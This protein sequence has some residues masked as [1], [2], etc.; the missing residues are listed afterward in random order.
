MPTIA[1]ARQ[2]IE[3]L[4]GRGDIAGAA[5]I[6]AALEERG[7][8]TDPSAGI[9]A[10]LAA[11]KQR[12]R[13]RLEELREQS[14][15]ASQDYV[16]SQ[17]GSFARG[18]DIGTD[19]IG[20]ATG[21]ALEGIGSLL[22]VEG[23]EQYGAEVALENEADAQRKSRYQT[24]FDDI[25]GA[26]DFGS[27]LGGLAGESSPQ[28]GASIA[29]G[30]AGAKI[31]AS[32]G[33]SILP[34]IGTAAGTLIGGVIGGTA[35][36]I[37][38]FFG[39][40]RERQ[41]DAIDR[42]LRTEVSE[43]AA[44]LSSIPQAA[45]D[46]VADRLLIGG[47]GL[48]SRVVG[49]GGIFTRGVKGAGTG[50]LAEVPTE[51]GQQLIE[52]AQAG[53]P[54][55]DEE[56]LAEYREAGI[57]GGLLGGSIRGTTNILGGD[58]AAREDAETARLEAEDAAL[59]AEAAA[60]AAALEAE[61]ARLEEEAARLEEVDVDAQLKAFSDEQLAD[62]MAP[63][64]TQLELGEVPRADQTVD[65]PEDS[66][67]VEEVR[68]RVFKGFSASARSKPLN[69]LTTKQQQRIA[70]RAQALAPAE[71][72]ALEEVLAQEAGVQPTTEDAEAIKARLFEGLDTDSFDGVSTLPEEQQLQFAFRS[73][74]L[75]RAEKKILVDAARGVTPAT[76]T[77]TQEPLPGLEPEKVGPQLQGLP[78]P[79]GETITVASEGEA[80]TEQQQKLVDAIDD[81]TQRQGDA[82]YYAEEAI[83]GDMPEAEVRTARERDAIA[84]REQPDLFPTEL[85]IAEDAKTGRTRVESEIAPTPEP[86]PE[87]VRITSQTL[88]SLAV[89]A[90]AP[91]RQEIP[92][93][94]LLDDPAVSP[95]TG[96][97]L[98]TTV[99]ERLVTYGRNRG[100]RA[101]QTNIDNLLQ[102]EPDGVSTKQRVL[103]TATQR[104]PV[105]A[106]DT[107][108]D[109]VD[110]QGVGDGAVSQDTVEPVTPVTRTVGDARPSTGRDTTRARKQ[111]DPLTKP[112]SLGEPEVSQPDTD[113]GEITVTFP[114]G[115]VR[116][117]RKKDGLYEATDRPDKEGTI[118]GDTPKKAVAALETQRT[119]VKQ[120]QDASKRMTATEGA[121]KPEAAKESTT[122]A[123]TEVTDKP[124][125]KKQEAADKKFLQEERNKVR[126]EL[127]A[128]GVNPRDAAEQ[129]R[130]EIVDNAKFS[131]NPTQAQVDSQRD[132]FPRT[133]DL[134]SR[135]EKE[136]TAER[137]RLL[138]ETAN[139][140]LLNA[141]KNV[142][143]N[144]NSQFERVVAGK[145]ASLMSRLEAAGIEFTYNIVELGGNT[146]LNGTSG[147]ATTNTTTGKVG[148]M[149]VLTDS[150][151]SAHNGVNNR[152]LLHEAIHATTSAALL[153]AKTDPK[154]MK[155]IDPQLFKDTQDLEDLTKAIQKYVSDR[156]AKYEEEKLG[157][158]RFVSPENQLSEFEYR[159]AKDFNNATQNSHEVLAWALTDPD[160]QALL[161]RISYDVRT[162][163]IGEATTEPRIDSFEIKNNKTSLLGALF[164]KIRKLF[165]F[166]AK[167]TNP[168]NT[169]FNE[170][171]RISESLYSQ[172]SATVGFMVSEKRAAAQKA[173]SVDVV[174]N[175]RIGTVAD[176]KKALNDAVKNAPILNSDGVKRIQNV[177]SDTSGDITDKAKGFALS[178]LSLNGLNMVAKKYIPKLDKVRD[179]VLEEGGRIQELKRPVD[180]TIARIATFAR[181]NKDK[182]D[183]LNRLMPYSSLVG[184][185]P[186]KPSSTYKDDAE[187][188]AEW[189]A[190]HAKDGDWT[191]L[192]EDGQ[193]IY[194]IVRNTY[195]NLYDEIAKVIKV[196]L[197]ATDLD[198]AK[199]K[200]V[201]DE[202]INKLYK[203]ATIDPYFALIREGKYRLEYT[204]TDPETGQAEYYTESFETKSARRE[205]IAELNAMSEEIKLKDLNP[206]ESL[207]EAKYSN[208]PSGSFV[209]NVLSVLS[210]N[211]VEAGVQDEIIKLFLD[212]LPERSF[213]QSFRQRKGTRG[214]I[215]DP[216]NLRDTKYPNHD[217]VRALRIRT[218]STARQIVRMEYGAKFS[219][220]QTELNADLKAYNANP[221]VSESDKQAARQYMEEVEKRIK[222]A[223][224]PEVEDWAKNLTTFGFT[225][226]LGMNLSSVVVN[227][228]QLPMVIA[229]HLAG[230]RGD[231]GEFF[232]YSDTVSAI[233]EATRLF[234]NAGKTDENVK[235][236]PF[237][238]K[239]EAP[240]EAI[241]PDGTEQVMVPAAPSI[242]NYDFDADGIPSEIKEF[243][244]LAKVAE[245]KGQLN[246]SIMY[247]TLDM[248]EIDSIRGK[249]GAY[250]G[251]MF[252]HGERMT[253]QVALA[254]A[255]RL[256]VDSM[257]R[258]ENN[259]SKADF[260]A[261][262]PKQKADLKLSDAK[263]REAADFAIYEVELTNGGT[264]AASAPRIGQQGIGKV[265]FL[266]K[267]YGI[268]M[269]ELLTRL[270]VDSVKGSKADKAAAR[271]QLAGT[272]GGAALV[273]G[274]QGLPLYGAVGMVY[275][276]LKGDEDEDFDTENRKFFEE[277]AY[278]GLGNYF[279]GVD[280]AS[281]MG[282]SDLIFRDRL[283][284]KDQSLI[285]DFIET[286]GGPVVGVEQGIE[287]GFD[288]MFNQGE[289]VRGVEAMSPAAI[290]NVLKSVRFYEEGARTQRGDV[291]V[292]DLHPALLV[293]QFFG[294]APAEYTRQLAENA[295]L[296][297]LDL[298]SSRQ[299]TN[300]LRQYYAAVRMGNYSKARKLREDMIEFSRKFPSARITP[301][302][303]KKSMASHMRTSKNTH[304]GVT[305]S[306]RMMD[307]M[308]QSASEY[309]DTITIWEDLGL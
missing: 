246:R 193:R 83:M 277:G 263:Y 211:K 75:T 280:V 290:R 206:F 275:N 232:G 112:K 78:A 18:I 268:Q 104:K 58:V 186:S 288:K 168:E 244:I 248:E 134:N 74:D 38:F 217:M 285:M 96:N 92:E 265:A 27:Y 71:L 163:K 210:A 129:A 139:G 177:V 11:D 60:E 219:E 152:T 94:A 47:L 212:T 233:G 250:S 278:G 297:K 170:L 252:H 118:L 3:V 287:R 161:S 208:A 274:V 182:V 131:T 157:G 1:Q 43:S 160:M 127:I 304:Y 120:Q 93:G 110:L 225:M 9:E 22:G 303:L 109:V 85:A 40:N 6:R 36:N 138:G 230:T 229:P 89:P 35:A 101:L 114:D 183:I 200:N 236:L 142:A 10:Q 302:T 256:K 260:K 19:T 111:R 223:K 29:G 119:G 164:S 153:L 150:A 133:K 155:Q 154:S 202:L 294:F 12:D 282:L 147:Q 48:T 213:A 226:T 271:R 241:G 259:L 102:G 192:G 308:K 301:E 124:V 270:T 298:K 293:G 51:I 84:Q 49:G 190:M 25:E 65:L 197:D 191:A 148:V 201:Y 20:Q 46:S 284:E 23:L 222:F 181:G 234:M 205:A 68:E 296:K 264:A 291:I 149:L 15:Q 187:K 171:L 69:E 158:S 175:A 176:G 82:A 57:A 32:I 5:S 143:R 166:S 34:G 189:D 262:T 299:R 146:E 286:I 228:S 188:L 121:R 145:V 203:N 16:E 173:G 159:A 17:R 52:R 245:E 180:A 238:K 267:R 204:A 198:P 62:A 2:A 220:A 7:F 59:E 55:A 140:T 91:I 243:A 207:E 307:D 254:A 172:D 87:P 86:T 123:T 115:E 306:S 44:F 50:A 103:P 289:F 56:A 80:R 266:Y 194:K 41:K 239:R 272:V 165:K 28:M 113:T 179:L 235:Y 169:A 122:E 76:E 97:P 90:S 258:A 100:S 64:G 37:P 30:V 305:F 95:R 108:S 309:D 242:D 300:L 141:V 132:D 214:F 218:A 178:L 249:I 66:V 184:V 63:A 237:L 167:S 31:G 224:N 8:S 21:S 269:M 61:T 151:L 281:R 156:L 39:M 70:K 292:D 81:R 253:R 128:Q 33:T 72:A 117:M 185:D 240:V 273:G 14:R 107:T 227:F 130:N 174:D 53:L 255:Y 73:Q 257:K 195:K 137:D 116:K 45:L 13:S 209:N 54:I 261:L 135:S 4:E 162:G 196:R 136:I 279:L 215:G 144:A 295:Q 199:R 88:D 126:K 98:P 251:F 79:Q 77:T 105:T 231:D 216:A 42:G 125:S 283:I 67:D 276:L 24:R 247:D 99:R 106:R 26:G 221:N